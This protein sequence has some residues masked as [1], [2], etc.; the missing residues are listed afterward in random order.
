MGPN[1]LFHIINSII[2]ME[3]LADVVFLRLFY[4]LIL[5]L[6]VKTVLDSS[7]Y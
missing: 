6:K 4:Q 2:Y 3:E 7:Y 1:S 5:I